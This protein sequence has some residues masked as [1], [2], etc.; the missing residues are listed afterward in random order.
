MPRKQID[1]AGEFIYKGSE[2]DLFLLA[3]NWKNYWFSIISPLIGQSVLEVGAG[4]GTT[5]K[6]FSDAKVKKWIA[7]EPDLSLVNRIKKD[8]EYTKYPNNFE[9]HAKTSKSFSS[10]YK[11]DTILYI[12]VLE[13]IK[14][15]KDELDIISKLLIP[16]GRII[17]LS[18]AHNFLYSPFDLSIGHFRR[19]NRK[20][21][22][23]V[24]PKG[25]KV[26]KIYYLD[27]VG[28]LA[29]LGNKLFLKSK[30]PS[31]RQ[32]QFWDKGLIPI[33]CILDRL[34]LHM[35][36]KTIIGVFQVDQKTKH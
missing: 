23:A 33:S 12:D 28:M 5:A 9:I 26:E 11:F 17:I 16:G 34:V 15:D 30:L 22:L 2:L 27:S 14:D 35:I 29:S 8:F 24:K 7:I 25:F 3:T 1:L 31:T 10:K 19:Y 4:I 32:I 36:G 20:S 21:L 6:L 13:H 18:P